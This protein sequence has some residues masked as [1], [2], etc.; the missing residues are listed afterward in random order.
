MHESH[1]AEDEGRRTVV[2]D[3][4]AALGSWKGR[5]AK[6]GTMRLP[7]LCIL[8]LLVA[9]LAQAAG[10]RSPR[11]GAFLVVGGGMGYARLDVQQASG[12]TDPAGGLAPSVLAGVGWHASPR[13]SV[14]VL[15]EGWFDDPGLSSI[16]LDANWYPEGWTVGGHPLFVRGRIGTVGVDADLAGDACQERVVAHGCEIVGGLGCD[17]ILGRA[18]DGT[19][20]W[21][22]RLTASVR[23]VRSTLDD[24][25]LRDPRA[26]ASGVVPQIDAA[27]VWSPWSDGRGPW[28]DDPDHYP[29][30]PCIGAALAYGHSSLDLTDASRQHRSWDHSGLAGALRLGLVA[31]HG[32]IVAEQTSWRAAGDAPYDLQVSRLLVGFDLGRSP[33]QLLLGIGSIRPRVDADMGDCVDLQEGWHGMAFSG[34]LGVRLVSRRHWTVTLRAEYIHAGQQAYY[35]DRPADGSDGTLREWDAGL[36]TAGLSV[37]WHLLPLGRP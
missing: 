28:Q 10:G 22:V 17:V 9:A 15:A 35:A 20:R 2:K 12:D 33:L 27:V 6:E 29:A 30:V 32:F 26:E 36:V 18:D 19:A 37:D 14:A 21:T 16:G 3:R 4:S 23:G 7:C 24:P 11:R 34:G 5:S 31:R 13:L 25:A 8:F 1:G